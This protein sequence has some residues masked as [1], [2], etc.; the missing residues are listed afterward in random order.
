MQK[1]NG[2]E[3]PFHVQ[4]TQQLSDY[5]PSAIAV[6]AMALAWFAPAMLGTA[7]T[8]PVVAINPELYARTVRRATA[9]A[10]AVTFVVAHNS[11]RSR[12]SGHRQRRCA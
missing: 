8:L 2:P 5:D 9:D 12:A 7:I 3:G 1:R 6:V 10:P 11:S 4:E